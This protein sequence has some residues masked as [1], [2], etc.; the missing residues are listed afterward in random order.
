MSSLRHWQPKKETWENKRVSLAS[1]RFNYGHICKAITWWLKNI[2][3]S[4]RFWCFTRKLALHSKSYK[5]RSWKIYLCKSLLQDWNIPFCCKPLKQEGRLLKKVVSGS[6]WNWSDWLALS[7]LEKT[8]KM[9]IRW[10]RAELQRRLW[11]QTSCLRE[12]ETNRASWIGFR[13][14][15]EPGKNTS[16]LLRCMQGCSVF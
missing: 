5:S 15:K 10:E 6:P 13:S 14:T 8:V 2:M 3:V 4:G 1:E 12:G 11:V 7:V 9:S 16:N